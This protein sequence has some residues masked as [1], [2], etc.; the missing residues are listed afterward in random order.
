[1]GFEEVVPPVPDRLQEIESINRLE[2]NWA[3]QSYHKY[4][5]NE[6]LRRPKMAFAERLNKMYAEFYGKILI[7]SIVTMPL[8]FASKRFFVHQANVPVTKQ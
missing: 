8:L 3:S 5:M 6:S 2:E 7:A 4:Y 1:M